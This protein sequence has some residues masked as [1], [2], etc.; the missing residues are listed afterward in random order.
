MTN[1]C[2]LLEK[3]RNNL[4]NPREIFSRATEFST[5]Q[6]WF[7]SVL[8]RFVVIHS[9]TSVMAWRQ[10][11]NSENHYYYCFIF[12]HLI[13]TRYNS[14]IL[15]IELTLFKS[16]TPHPTNS[17]F[18]VQYQ[19]SQCLVLYARCHRRCRRLFL[20]PCFFFGLFSC[21]SASRT[22]GRGG[23]TD[24]LSSVGLR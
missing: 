15:L 12:M 14:C 23:R 11:T 1:N 18:Y 4:K 9:Q 19:S 2:N 13:H 8:V 3:T 7:L 24:T 22:S 21:S 5:R 17:S 6:D 20:L 16:I 10:N